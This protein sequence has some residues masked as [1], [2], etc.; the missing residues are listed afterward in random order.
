MGKKSLNPKAIALML[1]SDPF[2]LFYSLAWKRKLVL[3]LLYA[4]LLVIGLYSYEAFRVAIFIL[5]LTV[6][7]IGSAIWRRR[8]VEPEASHEPVSNNRSFK[9]DQN[10]FNKKA[11]MRKKKSIPKGIA[12]PLFLGPFGLFYSL[13]WK[14]ALALILFYVL[15][16]P[17]GADSS[18][19]LVAAQLILIP[20][21]ISIGGVIWHNKQMDSE[22]RID[23]EDSNMG[24]LAHRDPRTK[25]YFGTPTNLES[26]SSNKS[27]IR[28]KSRLRA[29]R[30]Q[31]FVENSNYTYSHNEPLL[32]SYKE[33]DYS[34]KFDEFDLGHD[35][36]SPFRDVDPIDLDYDD[37]VPEGAEWRDPDD[38]PM[39]R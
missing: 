12:F 37:Q 33:S 30:S 38:D 24:A 19:V 34:E 29:P 2:G 1:F 39:S 8:Q 35:Y 7:D 28:P 3:I 36:D 17:I 32:D 22:A 20:M 4:L 23:S 31:S 21:V 27:G 11:R 26:L 6:I 13:G 9:Q 18:E 25:D 10:R 15:F 5:I 14:R 16:L